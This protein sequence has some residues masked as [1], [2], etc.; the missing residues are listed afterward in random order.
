M[1]VTVERHD[2]PAHVRFILSG[3]VSA[4]EVNAAAAELLALVAASG[5]SRVLADARE[6]EGGHGTFELYEMA[7]RFATDATARSV[8]EAVLLPQSAAMSSEL[9]FWETACVNRGLHVRVF[10]DEAAALAWLI[11]TS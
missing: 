10:D 5:V 9:R 3:L 6:L 8:R 2:H 4:A 7:E 11:V 1:P